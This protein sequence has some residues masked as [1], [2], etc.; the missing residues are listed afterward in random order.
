M[1]IFLDLA[2]ISTEQVAMNGFFELGIDTK[3]VVKLGKSA[4]LAAAGVAALK[5]ANAAGLIPAEM[6]EDPAVAQEWGAVLCAGS[7]WLI[8]FLRKLLLRYPP[9]D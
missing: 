2:F 4:L 3:G 8:N 6:A 5:G 1:R 7:I 9:Q